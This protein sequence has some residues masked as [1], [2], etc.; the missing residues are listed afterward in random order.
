MFH[1]LSLSSALFFLFLFLDCITQFSN[2]CLQVFI[3][4]VSNVTPC[5]QVFVAPVKEEEW[6]IIVSRIFCLF[7]HF[8]Y[9]VIYLF[10]SKAI[11]QPTTECTHLTAP[12]QNFCF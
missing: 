12:S 9:L 7:I 5:K 2:S 10:I 4:P 6:E 1:K 11:V 8:I 3:Q